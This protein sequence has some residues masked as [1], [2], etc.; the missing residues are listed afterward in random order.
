MPPEPLPI[1]LG[2]PGL[3]DSCG[4]RLKSLRV[5]VTDRCNLRCAY[6]L[7]EGSRGFCAREETLSFDEIVRVVRVASR[8]GVDHIRI[9]G[10]E[11]LLRPR[12]AELIGRLRA[13]TTAR[14][15]AL[16]T[17]GVLL[18]R[19][20]EALAAAGLDRL[21]VSAD[22]LRPDRFLAITGR[23]R[24][25]EVWEGIRLAA[26]AGLRPIKINVVV[27]RGMNED[28]IDA[29][30]EL[31]RGND[32]I[33]RFLELM[34]IGEGAAAGIAGRFVDLSEQRR[35]LE[36][37]LGIVRIEGPK[38]NGPARYWQIPGAKGV[39]GFIT[40]LSQS[41]C[42]TCSRFRL[43][44]RGELRPCLAYEQSVPLA[45]AARA[46]DEPAIEAGLRRAAAIKPA[47]H[48]WRDGQI[49]HT[50]MSGIGG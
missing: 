25:D 26:A 39:L 7:P 48:A 40:P 14:E 19:H 28:E 13:E 5:S 36:S 23:G 29:W 12:V 37:R 45:E 44:A 17:N 3:V 22:S 2:L 38:G 1:D 8:L 20:A 24:L 27:L 50:R 16:T 6:C 18:A 33:V 35:R 11:P 32:L 21:T 46:G 31:T 49:T 42:D 9:T 41:Y 4:R 10:G 30:A 43:T 34:P 47:G 15:V